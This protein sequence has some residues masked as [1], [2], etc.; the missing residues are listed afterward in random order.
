M[1]RK[2]LITLFRTPDG[3]VDLL[4]LNSISPTDTGIAFLKG[5]VMLGFV[6]V[7]DPLLRSQLSAKATDC[8]FAAKSGENFEQIDWKAHGLGIEQL[9]PKMP[10][11][12]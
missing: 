2:K 8:M 1:A 9:E 3:V 6:R 11:T 10:V 4:E 12:K 7:L 5:S